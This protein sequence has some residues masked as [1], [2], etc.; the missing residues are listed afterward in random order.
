MRRGAAFGAAFACA[1]VLTG[2]SSYALRGKVIEGDASMVLVVD[3][4]DSRLK[5]QGL[6][7]A[8]VTVVI[9]PERLSRETA[10]SAVSDG[11]GAFSVSVSE[12]GAG[13]LLYNAMVT[14]ECRGYVAAQ[15]ILA[16]PGQ[17]RRVLVV[18][19]RGVGGRPPGGENLL[20]EIRRHQN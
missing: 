13:V 19:Q 6:E 15:E 10:G 17:D 20:E 3:A 9:D 8:S 11:S 18:L 7:G 2:C 14:A 16:L 4:S 12:F 1:C 5:Q